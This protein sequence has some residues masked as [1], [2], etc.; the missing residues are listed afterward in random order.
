MSDYN[1]QEKSHNG[2][3]EDEEKEDVDAIIEDFV[4]SIS[5]TSTVETTAPAV[6]DAFIHTH[7]FRRYFVEFVHDSTLTT[8]RFVTKAWKVVVDAFIDEGVE[9][10]AMI[11][12]DG[13]N[14]E[15]TGSAKKKRRELV[16]RAVF[17]LNNMKV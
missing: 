15:Y 4:L 2:G 9:C 11:V 12:I 13:K 14:K 1:A 3:G 8:L 7:E 5:T 10:G 17:P 16:T 6:V